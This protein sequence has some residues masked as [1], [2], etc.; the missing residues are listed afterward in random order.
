MRRWSVFHQGC[1]PTTDHLA[2]AAG[3]LRGSSP[4]GQ[5]GVVGSIGHATNPRGWCMADSDRYVDMVQYGDL[6]SLKKRNHKPIEAKQPKNRFLSSSCATSR[7]EHFVQGSLPAVF[8]LQ[9]GDR[10]LSGPRAA[11]TRRHH[12]HDFCCELSRCRNAVN[13]GQAMG[14]H[15]AMPAKR[16]QQ[17]PFSQDA[18]PVLLQ[19][20][21]CGEDLFLLS[22]AG[23][24]AKSRFSPEVV[25]PMRKSQRE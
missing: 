23:P 9:G 14:V 22:L 24:V 18:G 1:M 12:R 13:I 4:R 16:R 5:G 3:S 7:L 25:E 2:D 8:T 19:P 11:R 15:A 17:I 10:F 6:Q 20:H 21:L